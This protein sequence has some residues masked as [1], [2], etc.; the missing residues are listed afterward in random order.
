MFLPA[1]SCLGSHCAACPV[2]CHT[3]WLQTCKHTE[4]IAMMFTLFLHDCKVYFSSPSWQLKT[5]LRSL[6]SQHAEQ[7]LNKMTEKKQISKRKVK[8]AF[9]SLLWSDQHL[10]ENQSSTVKHFREQFVLSIHAAHDFHRQQRVFYV[11]WK[12]ESNSPSLPQRRHPHSAVWKIL[13]RWRPI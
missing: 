7:S 2:C 3:Q 11:F 9:F 4:E 6:Q 13:T 10:R 1:F 12:K 8:G 5:T